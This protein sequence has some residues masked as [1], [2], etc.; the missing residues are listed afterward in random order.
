MHAP[1]VTLRS[2]DSISPTART[3]ARKRQVVRGRLIADRARLRALARSRRLT[4]R[5]MTD[6]AAQGAAAIRLR[7]AEPARPLLP[8]HRHRPAATS[9]SGC[10]RTLRTP[11][12]P[13]RLAHPGSSATPSTARPSP[14]S[15]S[16]SPSPQQHPNPHA[17]HA[18]FAAANL[19][20]AGRPGSPRCVL[21]TARCGPRGGG[22]RERGPRRTRRCMQKRP[23]ASRLG[24]RGL[25]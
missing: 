5:A 18:S 19:R 2:L 7:L 9:S 14:C 3:S 23:P 24:A 1:Q 25:F 8:G 12:P 16:S 6:T 11:R 10:A 22:R 13:H 20:R 21:M 4:D 17:S 15:N